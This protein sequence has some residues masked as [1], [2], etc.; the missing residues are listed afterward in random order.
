M[1]DSLITQT[2]NWILHPSYSDETLGQWSAFL[3][4]ILIG[5]FLWATVVS[6][7]AEAA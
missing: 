4:L 5:S 3:L 2:L 1:N 7:I 6:Q